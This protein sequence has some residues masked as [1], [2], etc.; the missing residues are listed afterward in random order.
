MSD[1]TL[2]AAERAWVQDGG[3]EEATR[4]LA[5]TRA[6]HGLCPQVER[7]FYL[8]TYGPVGR[9]YCTEVFGE[10]LPETRV[11]ELRPE[12]KPGRHV[13]TCSGCGRFA[14]SKRKSWR[15]TWRARA[16]VLVDV[17]LASMPADATLKEKRRALREERWSEPH[18]AGIKA[19]REASADALGLPSKR[20]GTRAVDVDTPLFGES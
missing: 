20:N 10:C 8:P 7:V 3:T 13:T 2:R 12:H 17:V 19:W 6:Q 14:S 18:A 11:V 5:R 1:E 9:D 15:A 16:R 4:M